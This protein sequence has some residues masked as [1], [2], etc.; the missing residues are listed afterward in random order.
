MSD[1]DSTAGVEL[2]PIPGLP[3]YWARADGEI[4]STKVSSTPKLK[5]RW[6]C[7]NGYFHVSLTVEGKPSRCT[8]HAL[9][10]RAFH[11]ERPFVGAEARHLNGNRTDNRA[12][13]LK[14]GSGSENQND[15]L[16]HGTR[17]VGEASPL[18]KLT[19]DQVAT[20]VAAVRRGVDC[21]Y[22]AR[23]LG[24]SASLVELAAKGRRRIHNR[25]S[26]D[27]QMLTAILRDY[28]S[29]PKRNGGTK[30]RSAK[31]TEREV[32]E[33]RARHAQGE[34]ARALATAFRVSEGTVRPLVQGKT[35]KHLLPTG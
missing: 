25:G 34:S 30:N 1:V 5:G 26:V 15:A 12:E 32:L 35:W 6:L 33:I 10:A 7:S 18:A 11:G 28:R 2:R 21:G 8:V 22:L 17:F 3:G 9:V 27:Q 29:Y 4:Y 20:I 23:R 24:V 16:Q 14:W 31:L 19:N 13:N